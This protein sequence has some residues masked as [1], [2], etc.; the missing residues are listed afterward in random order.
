MD[1]GNP[2]VENLNLEPK[3]GDDSFLEDE[4]ESKSHPHDV[5]ERLFLD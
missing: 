1:N 3:P 4:K 5:A 2:V